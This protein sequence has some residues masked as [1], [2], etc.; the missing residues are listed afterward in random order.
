MSRHQYVQYA[1]RYELA[2]VLNQDD[3]FDEAMQML[4]EAKNLV[5]RLGNIEAILREYDQAQ[6]I[7][8]FESR[9]G[10]GCPSHLAGNFPNAPVK[11]MPKWRSSEAIRAVARR[12]WS[13]FLAPTRAWWCWMSHAPLR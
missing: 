13:R 9:I 5:R 7:P 4:V 10:Q 6:P 1:S 11:P 3:R 8:P 12:C 2:E